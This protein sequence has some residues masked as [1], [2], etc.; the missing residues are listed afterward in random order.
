MIFLPDEVKTAIEKISKNGFEAYIVGGCVRDSLLG[1]TPKD[2]DITTSA[3]PQEVEKIF[4][5]CRVIET[6]IKHGTVTVL[7]NSMPLEITTFR[8]DSEYVDNRH[9]ESVTFTKSLRED[10]ARRDFTMNAIAYNNFTGICDFYGGETDIKNKIVRC[11]GNPDLRFNEDALRIMRAIRFS[12]VLGFEIEENTR[13]SIFKN[14]ELLKNI[15]SERIAAELVKLLCGK[16]AKKVLCEYIDILGVVMP[17]L[18]PMKDF[19]QRNAHHIY[20][21]WTH[22]AVAVENIEPA[23]ILRLTALF[24]D[25]GKPECFF[26]KNGQG[27]FYGH[28]AV[29]EKISDNIL[30]RLKFDN[31]SRETI[32]TLVKLHDIQIEETE[33]AVKR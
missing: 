11:V 18:L 9:P 23:P 24:H 13:S 2:Y 17:E 30:K 16:N 19:D 12:S 6:G 3:S 4:S 22:T 15:S 8:I 7:I 21:I 20:D 29:S 32:T 5:D 26:M 10:T 14:K 1:K 33:T 28:A 27:H 31:T 25:I